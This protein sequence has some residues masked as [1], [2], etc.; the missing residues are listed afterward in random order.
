MITM[1]AQYTTR[2]GDTVDFIA[3]RAYGSTDNK[4]VEAVL[5]ANPNLA[6]YGATLPAGLSITLPAIA[7]PSKKQGIKLWD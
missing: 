3:W 6:D 7:E 1:S 4:Q 2:E 5:E